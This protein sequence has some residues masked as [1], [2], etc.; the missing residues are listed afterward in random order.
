[1]TTMERTTTPSPRPRRLQDELLA[2]L[3][4]T[5]PLPIARPEVNR[6]ASVPAERRPSKDPQT[7]TIDVRVTP[8][9]WSAP[10]LR[11]HGTGKGLVLTA[12]PI[13]VSLTGFGR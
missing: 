12:G 8:L 2:D 13:R 10:S 6:S 3:R 9:R 4:Q 1:M 7:P 5:A 11:P